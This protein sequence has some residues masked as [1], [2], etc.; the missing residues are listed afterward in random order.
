MASTYYQSYTSYLTAIALGIK[1]ADFVGPFW[2][3]LLY[4][5]TGYL[6]VFLIQGSILLVSALS[7]VAFRMKERV[8][9]YFKIEKNKRL[10][11]CQLLK[12]PVRDESQS[13]SFDGS[14]AA[15][16]WNE[17]LRFNQPSVPFQ[18]VPPTR[19]QGINNRSTCL[20][21]LSNWD[22]HHLLPSLCPPLHQ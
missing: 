3:G 16:V 20:L 21:L 17:L 19:S 7:L 15:D 9:P 5:A 4:P 6:W 2:A 13:G 8:Y 1:A 10:S 14:S 12:I 22:A 11:Y 18:A